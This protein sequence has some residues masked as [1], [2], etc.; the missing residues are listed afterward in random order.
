MRTIDLSTWNKVGEGGNGSTYINP[1]EPDIILKIDKPAINT[2][3]FVKHE[4]EVTKAVERLGIQVPKMYEM[5]SVG[6]LYATLSQRIKGK[7]S[8]SRICCDEPDRI[9]EMAR[10]LCEQ[11]QKLFSTPCNTDLFPNRR[12]QLAKALGKV[13]FIGET[14]RRILADYAQTI[15]DATTCLHGDFNTGNLIQA[16]GGY[17]WIDLDRF[18]YGDPMF[19]LGHLFLICNIYA[20]M[21][22]VQDIFHMTEEQL[23]RFWLAFAKAYTGSDDHGDFDH[24]VAKFACL[25][26]VLRYEFQKCTL[27]EKLFF[28]LHIRRLI[29]R[30]YV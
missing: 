4:Y 10:V 25:D 29:K 17:Y 15:G 1:A 20:S 21:K 23:R 11:G 6:E 27:P 30:Y 7:K 22:Q 24:R 9:E 14:N 8:L 13:Q 5:V 16:E 26:I 3:E 2:F 18:G 28:S 19:D 12:E